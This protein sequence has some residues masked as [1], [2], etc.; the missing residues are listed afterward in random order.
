MDLICTYLEPTISSGLCKSQLLSR[1][2]NCSISK[3]CSCLYSD[4][5]S[6][7]LALQRLS[8]KSCNNLINKPCPFKFKINGPLPR[9]LGSVN[10][11]T[12]WKSIKVASYIEKKHIEHRCSEMTHA[13]SHITAC[14]TE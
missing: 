3:H 11:D 10:K 12:Y 4:Y 1:K 13:S 5:N 6:G 2:R 14:I 8:D 9:Q 7:S